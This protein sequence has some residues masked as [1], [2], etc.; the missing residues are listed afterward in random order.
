MAPLRGPMPN[1]FGIGMAIALSLAR[2]PT[3]S[4]SPMGSIAVGR[5]RPSRIGDDGG[6]IAVDGD[7][8]GAAVPV[9]GQIEFAVGGAHAVRSL[10]RL[11]G[12]DLHRRAG[13]AGRVQR[14]AIEIIRDHVVDVELV[15]QKGDAVDAVERA[16]LDQQFGL[17]SAGLEPENLAAEGVGD[18]ERLVRPDHEIVAQV[19]VA[20]ERPAQ[21]RRTAGEVKAAQDRMAVLAGADD[22]AGPQRVG[23]AIGEHAEKADIA[24]GGADV[25]EDLCFGCALGGA[26]DHRLRGAAEDQRTVRRFSHALRIRARIGGDDELG[27][28]GVRRHDRAQDSRKD[29]RPQ[30]SQTEGSRCPCASV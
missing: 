26:V 21:F 4:V 7:H 27:L 16:V 6:L 12:P 3:H 17:R 29:G 15:A 11:V 9:L 18:V 30:D 28:G 8:A 1:Y 5:V 20:G 19:D 14:N 10:D 22:L 2:S 13:L 23:R 25:D 24:L